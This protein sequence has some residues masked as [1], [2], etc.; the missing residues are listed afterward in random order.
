LCLSVLGRRLSERAG[1][2]GHFRII[3]PRTGRRWIAAPKPPNLGSPSSIPS[4]DSLDVQVR[5]IPPRL[6]QP[7]P[8]LGRESGRLSRLAAIMRALLVFTAALVFNGAPCQA[9]RVALVI[10]N[11]FEIAGQNYLLPTDVPPASEGEEELVKDAAFAIDRIIDRIQARG[12]RTTI[13]VLDACRNN[14]F[15]RP[16]T[17]AVGGNGGLAPLVPPEGTFVLFSAGA[18]QPALDAL[19]ENDP[20]PNSV[21][22]RHFVRDLAVPGMS[23]V[24]LAKRTQSAVKH[25]ATAVRHEQTPAYY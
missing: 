10:G 16:G 8:G 19:S 25:V 13:V 15:A 18:K 9:K 3:P 11:G 4:A 5:T 14:P 1:L 21:F 24:Q 20:D 7:R 23:L 6:E 2:G 12:A 17:R 22:T